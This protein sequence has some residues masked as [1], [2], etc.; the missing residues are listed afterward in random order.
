MF[1][2]GSREI[3]SIRREGIVSPT[4]IVCRVTVVMQWS[5]SCSGCSS[6]IT[7]QVPPAKPQF[8]HVLSLNRWRVQ[9]VKCLDYCMHV[10]FEYIDCL[11]VENQ[12]YRVPCS[13]CFAGSV[14]VCSHCG[15]TDTPLWRRTPE[16]RFIC[17]ACGIYWKTNHI[18]RP[19][20]NSKKPSVSG[21]GC[22]VC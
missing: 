20:R 14:K 21:A 19:V 6:R 18:H 4:L 2:R 10:L 3:Q 17:N 8:T 9:A 11:V 15:T 16:G 1:L 7:S 5:L 13:L 12:V 22:S